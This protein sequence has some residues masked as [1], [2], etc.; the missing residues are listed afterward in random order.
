MTPWQPKAL[1]FLLTMS[2]SFLCQ[3]GMSS[4]ICYPDSFNFPSNA[5]IYHG[6]ESPAHTEGNSAYAHLVKML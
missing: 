4:L 2:K 5:P 3:F 1:L 6:P